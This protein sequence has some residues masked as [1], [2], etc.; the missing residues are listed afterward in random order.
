MATGRVAVEAC[1]DA[2][3]LVKLMTN[4]AAR[5]AAMRTT[6]RVLRWAPG[7]RKRDMNRFSGSLAGARPD[8]RTW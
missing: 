4:V 3:R 1:A 8:E 6:G 5:I 7:A 2:P